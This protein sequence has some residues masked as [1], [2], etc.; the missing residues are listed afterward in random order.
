MERPSRRFANLVRGIG[1][2]ERQYEVEIPGSSERLQRA[3]TR[4]ARHWI[5]IGEETKKRRACAIQ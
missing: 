4:D 2:E 1:L 3:K 5:S